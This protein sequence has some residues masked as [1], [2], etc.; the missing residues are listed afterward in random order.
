MPL[1]KPK[2]RVFIC[3]WIVYTS[4]EKSGLKRL[5][6][7]L[8]LYTKKAQKAIYLS[9]IFCIFANDNDIITNT[10]QLWQEIKTHLWR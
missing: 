9:D 3:G 7:V 10:L 4:K 8:F 1:Y 5:I 6:L 2:F